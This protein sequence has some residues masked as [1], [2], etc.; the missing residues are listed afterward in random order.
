MNQA[1]EF[2]CKRSDAR[3]AINHRNPATGKP[4]PLC[5]P[6]ASKGHDVPATSLELHA[7]NNPE[8]V[9]IMRPIYRWAKRCAEF[10][11]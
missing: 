3:R 10:G 5:I 11:R 9:R 7:Y 1:P 6:C 8:H 2:V 4:Q